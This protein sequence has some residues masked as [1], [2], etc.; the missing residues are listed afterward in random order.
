MSILQL[1]KQL[2]EIQNRRG[3]LDIKSEVKEESPKQEETS[4]PCEV[5]KEEQ[6]FIKQ[7][8]RDDTAEVRVPH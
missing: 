1:K 2:E 8:Y 4:P 7:E 3:L 5:I 6:D